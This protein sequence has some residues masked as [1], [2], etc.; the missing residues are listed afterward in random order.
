MDDK[1]KS[2]IRK[3]KSRI[4]GMD[5]IIAAYIHGS[6]VRED[7]HSDC[8]ID[9]LLIVKDM[10]NPV[11]WEKS[12]K[13]V[14][15]FSP[16]IDITVIYKSEYDNRF[17][18]CWSNY[19][20]LKI[21]KKSLLIKGKDVLKE[22]D[23]Y[24]VDFDKIYERISWYCERTRGVI[25]N[26]THYSQEELRFWRQKLKC[27]IPSSIS[28][29]LYLYGIFEPNK[30]ECMKAFFKLNEGFR[31]KV[32]LENAD[33]TQMSSFLEELRDLCF[34]MKKNMHTRLGVAVVLYKRTG[35]GI[36][37]MLLQRNES[38]KGWEIV[39]GGLRKNEDFEHAAIR[40]TREES[41][42]NSFKS[43]EMT[44]H[45][46]SFRMIKNNVLQENVYKLVLLE[47]LDGKIKLYDKLFK[48]AKYFDK[49]TTK[50]KLIWPEYRECIEFASKILEKR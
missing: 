31:N 30:K 13:K 19:F 42:L 29:L 10:K 40:E 47:V 38:M 16:R 26:D 6:A 15:N 9:V 33:I 27:W 2:D 17:N 48:D 50:K 34:Y 3:I 5:E 18:V 22:F 49:E 11:S 37:Y 44:E 12:I 39:K 25:L 35:N 7:F 41:G 20:F 45:D 21:K 23:K 46:F 14:L 4:S 32:E 36:R 43:M 1:T 8:D 24:K 28:E